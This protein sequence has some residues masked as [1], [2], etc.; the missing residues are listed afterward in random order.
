M[1][2]FD[3]L[4][5][6]ILGVSALIGFVRGALRE[7]TTVAAFVIGVI[8]AIYA[9]RFVGHLARAALHPAWLGNITALLVVFLVV[10]VALRVI[11]GSVIRSVHNTHGAGHARPAGRRAAWAWSA[12]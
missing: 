9:L 7:V 12:A 6:A 5:L 4:A 2:L 3:I 1:T 8:A 10:Y 11:A